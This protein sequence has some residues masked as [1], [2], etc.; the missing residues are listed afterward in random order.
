MGIRYVVAFI[1]NLALRPCACKLTTSLAP[2]SYLPPTCLSQVS[3]A[4][5]RREGDTRVEEQS[6]Y[7]AQQ[8]GRNKKVT[9]HRS[10]NTTNHPIDIQPLDT[11]DTKEA[12][13]KSCQGSKNS[14]RERYQRTRGPN[15]THANSRPRPHFIPTESCNSRPHD[16]D[17]HSRPLGEGSHSRT[18]GEGPHSRPLGEGSHSRTQGEGPHSRPLG[19]GS[20]SRTQGEGPHSRPLSE[21]PNY[22]QLNKRPHYHRD[23]RPFNR[24]YKNSRS[25]AEMRQ[26]DYNGANDDGRKDRRYNPH[27]IRDE[28][29]H[30]V[31]SSQLK[32]SRDEHYHKQ[33]DS[34]PKH[35]QEV[36]AGVPVMSSNQKIKNKEVEGMAVTGKEE[37]PRVEDPPREQTC[38]R[39][40]GAKS[41]HLSSG[42]NAPRG[43]SCEARESS[44]HRNQRSHKRTEKRGRTEDRA[45][46]AERSQ[47]PCE[48]HSLS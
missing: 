30:Q 48:H 32:S 35:V 8:Q 4:G 41:R 45:S 12:T 9:Q 22:T 21:G 1:S 46:M 19:E 43:R 6:F 29:Y 3:T 2:V 40:H 39:E 31:Y 10:E 34:K 20:H 42:K 11:S 33:R 14:V 17:P 15:H 37:T 16:E 36:P 5:H 18:Q 23:H 26:A 28:N 7:Q 13:L 27:H 47:E 24:V 44:Y 38:S 25:S